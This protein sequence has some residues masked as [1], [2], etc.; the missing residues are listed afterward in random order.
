MDCLFC[1]I[2]KG[3]IPCHKVYEDGNTLAFLDIN[4]IT[5]G[6]TV[7]IPKFH[8]ETL[9]DLPDDLVAELFLAVKKITQ[10]I[11]DKLNPD[12]F[13]IGINMRKVAGQ[14]VDHLHI[15]ILPRWQ[16]DGGGSVHTIIHNPPKQSLEE[17]L[18]EIRM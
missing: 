9:L 11:K 16:D 14:A 4:P 1:K 13:N 18:K 2:V 15:H 5:K 17:I 3:E 6:H 12:G 8:A 7:V 10:N